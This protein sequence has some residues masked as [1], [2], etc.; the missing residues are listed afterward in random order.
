MKTEGDV[1]RISKRTILITF[2]I[3]LFV[4]FM[5]TY[6][7]PYYVYKPGQA[8]NLDD[9]VAVEHGYTSKGDLHLVTVSGGQVTPIQYIAAKILPYHE[10]VPIEEARPEGITDEEY[11]HYQLMLMEGSQHSSMVVAYEAANKEVHIDFNGI[12]VMNVV[13]NMPAEGK[14][15]MGDRITNIDGKEVK[16]ANELVNYVQEKQPGDTI[17]VVIDRDGEKRTKTIEV[18]TFPD[19]KEKVGIGIQ[20]VTDQ[21]ITVHPEVEIKSGKIGGPSA[22]L[23][24]ALEMYN[25]LMTEDI[26]KGYHIA[27][28]GEI[29]FDGNVHRIGGIDKKVVAADR[30]GIEIFFAPNENGSENSNYITAKQTAEQI[31]TDM[32][33]VPVDSFDD[34]L[35]YLEKLDPK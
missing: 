8:D 27:G 4:F 3:T 30:K 2:I 29:D 5:A 16:E 15:K 35:T 10:M 17:E 23:M 11:M 18:Q 24:F 19:D 21:K 28:T 1:L 13:E 9:I 25:Q 6:D 20:L 12:Y 22:G 34:A 7:L 32:E 33:I 31:G 26:T 14:I